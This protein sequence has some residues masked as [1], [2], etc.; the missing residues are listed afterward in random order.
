MQKT[1]WEH[2]PDLTEARLTAIADILTAVR[3]DTLGLHDE[4]GGDTEWSLGCRIYDR[5]RTTLIRE[6]DNLPW[7]EII[8]PTLQFIFRVG[9]VPVRFYHG[10]GNNPG[11][12][13]R[14]CFPELRQQ[15][16]AFEGD[17][18]CLSWRFAVE[19]DVSGDVS[20]VVVIG[21]TES[22]E[23][24]CYY[25]VPLSAT[26]TAIKVADFHPIGKGIELEPPR[27][28]IAKNR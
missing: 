17:E 24:R 10:D 18:Q 28:A 13:T 15:A 25:P 22:G 6:A 12:R 7:L 26:M 14:R 3:R 21:A 8:D 5:S 2:H 11:V 4:A 1:P 9:A 16:I 20:Q 19:S 27:V 23:V